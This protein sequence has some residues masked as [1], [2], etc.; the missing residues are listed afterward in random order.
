MIW[1]AILGIYPVFVPMLLEVHLRRFHGR[2]L[3]TSEE[4]QRAPLVG[5]ASFCTVG[6]AQGEYK[7]LSL[8]QRNNQ[9]ESG[10]LLKLYEPV[11]AGLGNDWIV[12]RGFEKLET[13]DGPVSF[14]QEWRCRVLSVLPEV[15]PT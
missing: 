14:V 13:K 15:T 1:F 10:T 2:R 11:M 3:T 4:R 12:F 9:T 5:D 7:Q 6:Y 8:Q